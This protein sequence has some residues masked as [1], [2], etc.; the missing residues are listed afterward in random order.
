MKNFLFTI[1]I[2]FTL[3]INDV[4]SQLSYKLGIEPKI[5]IPIG[6]TIS[7]YKTGYG[8]NFNTGLSFNQHLFYGINFGYARFHAKDYVVGNVNITENTVLN[9]WSFI[10]KTEYYFGENKLQP[11]AGLEI[12]SNYSYATANIP[13]ENYTFVAKSWNLSLAA[14][15]GLKYSLT[16]NWA[17][18][19]ATQYTY[20]YSKQGYISFISFQTGLVYELK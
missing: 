16:E 1:I 14:K 20:L 19:A 5:S 10:L 6:E 8:A 3:T 15:L 12:G 7:G 9:L 17:T 11:Y 18:T 13:N 4:H 2:C